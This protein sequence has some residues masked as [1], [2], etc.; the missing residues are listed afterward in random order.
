MGFDVSKIIK[1]LHPIHTF[2]V[3]AYVAMPEIGFINLLNSIKILFTFF[4]NSF[5]HYTSLFFVLFIGGNVF[6]LLGTQIAGYA[7]VK[8]MLVNH[9]MI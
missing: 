1:V 6:Q 7:K 9:Y 3:V 2:F 8:F 5:V 4:S